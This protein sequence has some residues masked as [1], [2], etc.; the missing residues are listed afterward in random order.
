MKDLYTFD[1]STGGALQT[2]N[3]I[4]DAYRRIF[5]R[6]GLK[7]RYC[8]AQADTGQWRQRVAPMLSRAARTHVRHNRRRLQSRVSR[9]R[10]GW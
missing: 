2:Y 9:A 7:D 3:T 5:E 8:V 6:V 1:A 10:V 4:V